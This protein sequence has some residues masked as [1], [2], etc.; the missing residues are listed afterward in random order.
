MA[1]NRK[2]NNKGLMT[3]LFVL[4]AILLILLI[5]LMLV[6]FMDR[7]QK[8]QTAHVVSP[9][10][11][12][13]DVIK[14]GN[15][16]NTPSPT[17][18][19]DKPNKDN[20]EK[21]AT[22][23]PTNTPIPTDTP[24]P[25]PAFSLDTGFGRAVNEAASAQYDEWKAGKDNVKAEFYDNGYYVSVLL[26]AGNDAGSDYPMTFVKETGEQ[27]GIKDF[28]RES[29]LAVIKERLQKYVLTVDDVFKDS[30]FIKYQTPY[31]ASDYNFF[32]MKDGKLFFY[33][34]KNTL[35][36]GQPAFYYECDLN[37]ATPYL[38]VNTARE[39]VGQHIRMDLDPSKPMVAFT[40]DD[41]PRAS[42]ENHFFDLIEK[43]NAR[44]TFFSVGNRFSTTGTWTNYMTCLKELSEAGCEISSHTYSHDQYGYYRE[45]KDSTGKVTSTFFNKEANF[46]I[47]WQEINKN[48]EIIASTTGCAPEFIRMPGGCYADYMVNVP[49]PMVNWSVSTEDWQYHGK[50]I[51]LDEW[52]GAEEGR[53][54]VYEALMNV[55]DGDIVLMHSIYLYTYEA[56]EK[57]MEEL[58]AQGYQ[59]VNLSELFYYK[60]LKAENGKLYNKGRE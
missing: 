8:G 48:T 59:F 17:K 40:Y 35:T 33:F 36:D 11:T 3:L 37:D 51:K 44:F 42:V 29:Y 22:P 14:D 26:T 56:T 30:E 54:K 2:N 21:K 15:S 27:L 50:Q 57:A 24:T 55:K 58:S 7:Y 41:G 45:T 38:F 23:T 43:Y 10:P 13:T 12:V 25:T 28:V 39:K 34:P 9:A 47:F 32:Y 16:T 6:I 20:D 1:G 52:S 60:G 18:G 4:I 31:K 19:S 49:M 46:K 5:V 53:Q